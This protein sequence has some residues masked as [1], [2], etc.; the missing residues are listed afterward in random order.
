MTARPAFGP[1][2]FT[3]TADELDLVAARTGLRAMLSGRLSRHHVA[4]LAAF[5]LIVAFAAILSLTGLIARRLG[6]AILIVAALAFMMQRLSAH[7]RLRAAQK[8]SGARIERLKSAGE[9]T[10]KADDQ[11]VSLSNAG[12]GVATSWSACVEVEDAG[13]I[14][15]LWSRDKEPLFIPVRALDGQSAAVLSFARARI[16]TRT[17]AR[18]NP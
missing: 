10:L 11:G 3:P 4:P 8:G 2:T 18:L 6:E 15:Y 5:V 12:G 1:F 17:T 7:W 13:G 16:S 9:M 14:L